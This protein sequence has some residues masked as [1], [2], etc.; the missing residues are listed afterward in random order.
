M[1]QYEEDV[2]YDDIPTGDLHLDNYDHVADEGYQRN[3]RPKHVEALVKK[4]SRRKAG[5]LTVSMRTD[6]PGQGDLFVVDGQHRLLAARKK[7]GPGYTLHCLVTPMSR[8]EEALWF[9]EQDDD[10]KKVQSAEKFVARRFGEDPETLRIERYVGECGWEIPTNGPK[11]TNSNKL[12]SVA[13]VQ[14]IDRTYGQ[15]AVE[16]ALRF[17]NLAY[18]DGTTYRARLEVVEGFSH[19]LALYPEVTIEEL[20]IKMK[21]EGIIPEE[22]LSKMGAWKRKGQGPSYAVVLLVLAAWNTGKR[23]RR[24][25]ERT[26]QGMRE[27]AK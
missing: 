26:M 23:T 11:S 24:L 8:R 27:A 7:Y 10:N 12:S 14:R 2:Y 16:R 20:A 19:F 13:S 1:S 18:P 17:I 25:P 22:I 3:V 15:P 21:L 4:W 5:I 6:E 9:A